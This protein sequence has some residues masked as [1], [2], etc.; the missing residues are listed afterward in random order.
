[1]RLFLGFILAHTIHFSAVA[2]LAVLTSGENIRTRGGWAVVLT[3]AVLFYVAAFGILRSWRR[4]DSG[5][6]WSRS[7]R[8][9]AD[10]SIAL[11]AMVFLN[12]Y[13]SRVQI[14]PLY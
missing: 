3:A 10:V 7:D 9:A 2:W 13:L 8:L 6:S 5:R 1:M 14:M 11:I 12:S 4:L